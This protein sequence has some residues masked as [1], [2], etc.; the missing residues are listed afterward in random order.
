[1]EK[2]LKLAKE[3]RE[4]K[5]YSSDSK[6]GIVLEK[7]EELE[8]IK[9]L[10]ETRST[11]I[12]F[13]DYIDFNKNYQENIEYFNEYNKDESNILLF[14]MYY[15]KKSLK[16]SLELIQTG[17]FKVEDIDDIYGNTYFQDIVIII[18]S[19]KETLEKKQPINQIS[20]DIVKNMIILPNNLDEVRALS[21]ESKSGAGINSIKKSVSAIEK[22]ICVSYND[23]DFSSSVHKIKE[24]TGH[25]ADSDLR[26]TT[27]NI[28][29]ERYSTGRTTKVGFFKLP[30]TPSNM[31][32]L[33]SKLN[34]PNAEYIYF[35]VGFGNFKD[36]G[37]SETDLYA[38]FI[39]FSKQ[40]ESYL[41]EL[42]NIVSVPF[43][44]QSLEKMVG[45]I[46]KSQSDYYE[47]CNQKEST[48][49]EHVI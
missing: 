33:K 20:N 49:T 4:G 2:L 21:E 34:Y 11:T 12:R 35:V 32:K 45:T 28:L 16:D 3:I 8:S 46:K 6:L 17:E 30:I 9:N 29:G 25:G 14:N 19:I 39:E 42:V 31:E 10:L 41:Q 15:L 48:K 1:M 26:L 37:M 13:Q 7:L 18:D 44:P 36:I 43:T 22:L 24:T 27:F 40:Q 23:T 5:N 47:M 38:H